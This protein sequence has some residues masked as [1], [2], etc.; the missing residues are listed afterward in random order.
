MDAYQL[1]QIVFLA[2][3]LE[4][5]RGFGS[6]EM[7]KA[8]LPRIFELWD[9]LDQLQKSRVFYTYYNF[10]L[11]PEGLQSK[12]QEFSSSLQGM[13]YSVLNN[14]VWCLMM[15][16]QMTPDKLAELNLAVMQ[17]REPV[18]Q[19]FFV[20]FKSALL[21]GAH[22]AWLKELE[23]ALQNA[24]FQNDPMR[25]TPYFRRDP[26]FKALSEAFFHKRVYL[27]NCVPYLNT[28]LVDFQVPKERA[29]L[30]VAT[31]R[32]L[33]P[34]DPARTTGRFD[35][36]RNILELTGFFC[37]AV[38]LPEYYSMEKDTRDYEIEDSLQEQVALA[39][40]YE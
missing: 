18:P 15:S 6:R 19:P 7:F 24:E 3:K 14:V 17:Q 26:E 31:S 25:H 2:S 29:G 10:K 30:L 13:S 38:R 20:T 34:W 36:K 9:Q 33:L 32:H 8:I 22:Q 21:F 16:Y 39:R 1:G 35:L 28:F 40:A 12:F 23:G 5:G 37:R 11:V 27:D 4:D